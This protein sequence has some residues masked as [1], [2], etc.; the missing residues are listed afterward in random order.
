MAEREGFEPPIPLRGHL[1]SNQA[2]ST[3]LP[4]LRTGFPIFAFVYILN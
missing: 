2:R 1:I 4:P 3:A